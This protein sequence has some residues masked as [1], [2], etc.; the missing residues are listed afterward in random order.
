MAFSNK[1]PA[2]NQDEIENY[3]NTLCS[4]TGKDPQK[5]AQILSNKILYPNYLYRYRSVNNNNLEALRTNKIYLSQASKYDDPFDTYLHIDYDRLYQEL[6]EN[7]KCTQQTEDL[8]SLFKKIFSYSNQ[9]ISSRY[10]DFVTASIKS[11]ELT[12]NELKD[13]FLSYI[14]PFGTKIQEKVFSAC[15][16]E[17]GFNETLWL[18]YADMHKGFVL[19]YDLTNEESF[20]CGKKMECENCPIKQKGV[21]IYPVYY[22]DKPY[23]ATEFAKTIMAEEIANVFKIPLEKIMINGFKSPIWEVEKNSLIKKECHKYDQEW[24]MIANCPITPPV[25]VEWIPDS[26]ILGLRTSSVDAKLIISMAKQAGI[27]NVYQSYIDKSNRLNAFKISEEYI[28]KI[29]GMEAK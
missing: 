6:E 24:R 2:M 16:S 17:N 19:M 12:E 25:T 23:D 10:I 28:C 14:L 15:F 3:W 20:I 1:I 11:K 8:S 7:Y 22:T 29:I 21:S 9:D 5:E 26:V 4:F 27:K 18:K 13:K